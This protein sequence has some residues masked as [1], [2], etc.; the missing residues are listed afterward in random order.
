[1]KSNSSSIF[2]GIVKSVELVHENLVLHVCS[3][4]FADQLE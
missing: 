3:E 4:W 1:M 2:V